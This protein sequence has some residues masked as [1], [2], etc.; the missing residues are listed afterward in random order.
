MEI[1][2]NL[3][4][5][6]KDKSLELAWDSGG[7]SFMTSLRR[8]NAKKQGISLKEI[9]ETTFLRERKSAHA[10]DTKNNN[11]FKEAI[12]RLIERGIFGE[13]VG[14]HSDIKL[15]IHSG[16]TYENERFLPWHR[17]YLIQFEKLL[18]ETFENTENIYIP[19]WDWEVN[20]DVP[21]WLNDFTPTVTVNVRSYQSPGQ[22][23]PLITPKQYT[24]KRWP[25]SFPDTWLPSKEEIDSE[26][27]KKTK[28]KDFTANLED[29]HGL[30]HM[31]VGGLDPI[32]GDVTNR[33]TWGTMCRIEISPMDPIFWL[34][35]ANIDRIWD[36]WQS[37]PENLNKNPNLPNL[38]PNVDVNDIEAV[39][40]SG[41]MNPW[42]PPY[43]ESHTRK[44]KDLGYIYK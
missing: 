4:P 35:H 16:N 17:I 29:Y 28:F 34:H 21:D 9:K 18:N 43:I 24:V 2:R 37:K 40:K 30:V 33:E 1:K 22:T 5:S 27:R 7:L 42:Y 15:R 11:L 31:W 19:Y 13:F 8:L 36:K 32:I 41:I 39:L 23:I 38:D 10:N 25:G 20:R 12:E 6:F 26:V 44:T 14:I 3:I